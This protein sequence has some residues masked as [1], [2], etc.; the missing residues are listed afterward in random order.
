MNINKNW[1]LKTHP[2]VFLL[3]SAPAE[4]VLL[5]LWRHVVHPASRRPAAHCPTVLRWCSGER[6]PINSLRLRKKE[7]ISTHK[8]AGSHWK[9]FSLQPGR[10]NG[11]TWSAR[12][13]NQKKLKK[14]TSS[15]DPTALSL[16]LSPLTITERLCCN[17][18]Y[19]LSGLSVAVP[20]LNAPLRAER[21]RRQRAAKNRSTYF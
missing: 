8:L 19:L 7:T 9:L 20:L 15:A 17:Q 5:L 14:K 3:S 6:N 11:K 21:R 4:A 12:R 16:S 18:M 13:K 10:V 2:L 1:F